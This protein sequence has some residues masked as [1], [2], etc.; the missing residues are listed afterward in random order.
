MT[1]EGISGGRWVRIVDL[2]RAEDLTAEVKIRLL[3]TGIEEL[4][5]AQALVM[6]H[7]HDAGM[8]LYVRMGGHVR[9]DPAGFA[10]IWAAP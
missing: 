10:V 8:D 7:G 6:I 4:A 9:I 2:S 3:A 1:S 5:T